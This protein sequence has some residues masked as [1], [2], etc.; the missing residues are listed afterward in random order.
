MNNKLS[1][2][3]FDPYL[4]LAPCYHGLVIA[5]EGVGGGFDFDRQ[6]VVAAWWEMGCCYGKDFVQKRES[7]LSSREEFL[8]K[9]F[10]FSSQWNG[11]TFDRIPILLDQNAAKI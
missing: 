9:F 2:I 10:T 8:R 5:S 7:Y 11:K 1:K 6:G 3:Y 4:F